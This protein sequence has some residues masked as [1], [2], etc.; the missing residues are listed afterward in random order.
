MSSKNKIPVFPNLFRTS[1][2]CNLYKSIEYFN[3]KVNNTIINKDFKANKSTIYSHRL[4]PEYF[5]LNLRDTSFKTKI[6]PECNW[7]YSIL[8]NPSDSID[9]FMQRQFNSKKRNIFTRYVKRLETCFDVEY[10]MFYGNISETNYNFIMQSLYN[11]IVARFKERNELHKNLH[12]WDYLLENTFS[13]II[14]KKASLFVIYNKDEPIEISLNYH[15]DK[16]LFSY[17][18]SYNIDYSK[19]GLGHIEIYKQTEWCAINGYI[20]FEMGVGGMDY[21]RRWSNNIYRYN[22]Y[23]VYKKQSFKLRL[24]IT[25]VQLKEYLKSKK[26]NEF[27]PKIKAFFKKEDTQQNSILISK[28]MPISHL[29]T[30]EYEKIEDNSHLKKYINNFLYTTKNHINDICIYK[31][32]HYY[33]IKGKEEFQKIKFNQ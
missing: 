14:N 12:E 17:L 26:V 22:H 20:L 18:S 15:F 5:K 9:G 30:N 2:I 13:D 19:F 28:I 6:I 23:V 10:R 24:L 31:N 4:I 32:E 11:M 25:K 27:Y 16:V 33:I 7:G 21:K 8:L 3:L 29:N 1:T